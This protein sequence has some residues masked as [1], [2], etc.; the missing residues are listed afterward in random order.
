MR[1]SHFVWSKPG[2]SVRK[3]LLLT[4]K[5]DRYTPSYMTQQF[6]SKNHLSWFTPMI[7]G[8]SGQWLK[9]IY[10]SIWL[11]INGNGHNSGTKNAIDMRF[12][13]EQSL[14]TLYMTYQFEGNQ[15]NQTWD[16]QHNVFLV[17]A[18]EHWKT[19]QKLPNLQH[20]SLIFQILQRYHSRDFG[21]V[22]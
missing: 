7:W 10:A 11:E 6:L 16:M 20:S 3:L 5:Y 17:T 15:T 4:R 14:M 19:E 21:F 12:L 1:T 8:E 9:S 13:P 2:I 18:Q 22:H